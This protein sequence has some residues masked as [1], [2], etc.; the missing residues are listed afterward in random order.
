M[1]FIAW[2]WLIPAVFIG[3]WL[4]M[5]LLGLLVAASQAHRTYQGRRGNEGTD[6]SRGY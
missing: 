2:V 6:A 4:R 5:L 3:A 1:G